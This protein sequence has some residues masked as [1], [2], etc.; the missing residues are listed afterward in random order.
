M[1]SFQERVK[2]FDEIIDGK[3][4]NDFINKYYPNTSSYKKY[5]FKNSVAEA[6]TGISGGFGGPS[7]REYAS[8]KQ[9]NNLQEALEKCA[10]TCFGELT[11]KHL[12]FYKNRFDG[13]PSFNNDPQDLEEL[14]K[15]L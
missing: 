11:E 1:K 13:Y 7:I 10:I 14:E 12:F 2:A 15:M 9:V 3:E 6:V 8:P 4:V 5:A